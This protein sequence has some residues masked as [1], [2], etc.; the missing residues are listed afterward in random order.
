MPDQ[1]VPKLH[2]SSIGGVIFFAQKNLL[3]SASEG[4]T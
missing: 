2:F 1:T 3:C 4:K